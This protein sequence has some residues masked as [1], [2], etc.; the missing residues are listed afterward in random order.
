[1]KMKTRRESEPMWASE[2]FKTNNS[3]AVIMDDRRMKELSIMDELRKAHNMFDFDLVLDLTDQ[4]N[5]IRK[6]NKNGK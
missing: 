5:T 2:S 4:L 6:E 1:M 3:I